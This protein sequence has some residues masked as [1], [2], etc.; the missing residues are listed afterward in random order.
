[1]IIYIYIQIS[2]GQTGQT[3]W[4]TVLDFTDRG[5]ISNDHHPKEQAPR[6]ISLVA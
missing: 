2:T 4:E 3:A 1:M 5:W 6:M